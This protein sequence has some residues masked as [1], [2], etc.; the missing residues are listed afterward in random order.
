MQSSD[1]RYIGWLEH[2]I[3]DEANSGGI[4]LRG[5][6]QLAAEDLDKDGFVDVVSG[7][8]GSAHV[9]VAYGSDEKGEWFRLSLAEGEE[10]SRLS[11][12]AL[13]D[14]ND[15]GD[16]DA[17]VAREGAPLLYLENP[18]RQG[19]GFRW[20]RSE[21]AGESGFTH[22]AA[23]DFDSDGRTEIVASRPGELVVISPLELDWTFQALEAPADGALAEVVDLDGDGDSDIVAGWEE[24]QSLLW[25]ENTGG[26]GFTARRIAPL[27]GPPAFSRTL[28]FGDINGDRRVDVVAATEHELFWLEHPAEA[29]ASWAA[30][31]IGS[32]APDSIAGL[33]L[34]D[35]DGDG[36]ADIFSGSASQG[37]A[38]KDDESMGADAALGRLVWFANPN[39]SG[40]W[41]RHEIIRRRRGVFSEFLVRDMD[42]DG[43]VDL[44]GVRSGSGKFDGFFWLEQRHGGAA[45]K[46]FLPARKNDSV[47]VSAPPQ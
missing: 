36:A 45:Q 7:F 29:D 41:K 46:A 42:D 33:A 31:R 20:A 24:D 47:I 1:G 12:I 44:L 11:D 6:A 15:D 40:D 22:V 17:V 28:A 13:A 21:V 16:I 10:A 2:A 9:R 39:G 8:T 37:P 4:E 3:D 34:A 19:R 26:A 43:D 25:H 14:I 38:D 23:A 32:I 35:I 27:S 30:H 5:A 18:N